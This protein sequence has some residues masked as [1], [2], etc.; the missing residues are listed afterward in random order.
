MGANFRLTENV[1]SGRDAMTKTLVWTL[2]HRMRLYISGSR[3]GDAAAPHRN[4]RIA[5]ES[6]KAIGGPERASEDSFSGYIIGSR[7]PQIKQHQV[8]YAV[9]LYSLSAY[10]LY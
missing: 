3:S 1:D 6:S 10:M 4:P 9:K 7:N 8:N 2:L 5:D